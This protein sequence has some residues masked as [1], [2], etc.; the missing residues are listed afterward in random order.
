MKKKSKR[1]TWSSRS[2]S[3]GEANDHGCGATATSSAWG[4]AGEWSMAPP[5]LTPEKKPKAWGED[6]W[7]P[8]SDGPAPVYTQED[9]KGQGSWSRDSYAV[10]WGSACARSECGQWHTQRSEQWDTRS[11][12]G[13]PDAGWGGY[14][15][16]WAQTRSWQGRQSDYAGFK[17]DARPG[18]SVADE[19]EGVFFQ[20]AKQSMRI[21]DWCCQKGHWNALSRERCGEC[22]R[23][24][25]RECA[26]GVHLRARDQKGIVE[27]REYVKDKMIKEGLRR[28]KSDEAVRAAE[29]SED[30]VLRVRE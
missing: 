13:Q 4:S 19:A 11:R 5:T 21:G 8:K 22:D 29:K 23:A 7:T 30:E 24:G 1:T 10:G 17:R 3:C 14:S 2:G 12:S 28:P 16:S 25:G 9:K 6:T 18:E 20:V 27:L 15:S 26:G